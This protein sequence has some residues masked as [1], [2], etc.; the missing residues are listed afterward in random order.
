MDTNYTRMFVIIPYSSEINIEEVLNRMN[1]SLTV[2]NSIKRRKL[3]Y[4][5]HVMRNDKY[6]YSL[7]H[8][9][10]QGMIASKES[11]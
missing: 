8:L 6:I 7:L 4:L 10:F 1:T 5:G 2:P 11:R 9:I 3:E